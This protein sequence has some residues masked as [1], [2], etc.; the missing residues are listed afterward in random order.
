VRVFATEFGYLRPDWMTI[1]RDATRVGSSFPR[2]PVVIRR[3][4]TKCPP[5]DLASRYLGNFWRLAAPDVLYNLANVLFHPLYPHYRQHTLDH[6]VIDY[7]AGICRLASARRRHRSAEQAIRGLLDSGTH[8]YLLPLQLDWDFR[9]R[10]YSR[11]SGMAE[12]IGEVL[13]IFARYAPPDTHL[14][15][16]SH[17]LEEGATPL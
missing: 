17:P 4:A 2:D 15:V 7:A 13:K 11:F 6:P 14:L 8:F 16:K 10:E 9:A 1:E 3:L 5:V 12:L